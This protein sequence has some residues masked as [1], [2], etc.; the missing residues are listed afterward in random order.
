MLIF[1]DYF[2]HFLFLFSLPHPPVRF[3]PSLVSRDIFVLVTFSS[4][5]DFPAAHIS[6]SSFTSVHLSR[7]FETFLTLRYGLPLFTDSGYFLGSFS[8]P[9]F[10]CFFSPLLFFGSARHGTQ[11]LVQLGKGSTCIPSTTPSSF[12]LCVCLSCLFGCVSFC[13]LSD[14]PLPSP[15]FPGVSRQGFPL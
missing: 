2:N 5:L 6:S 8:P 4:L 11:N 1:Y 14:P 13:S 10:S 12:C 15:S 9:P 7:L 3:L